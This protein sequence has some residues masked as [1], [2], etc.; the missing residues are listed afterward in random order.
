M[1]NFNITLAVL[2]SISLLLA[3]FSS[4]LWMVA[5]VFLAKIWLCGMTGYWI[6]SAVVNI[7][8]ASRQ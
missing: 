5:V 2:T 6:A 3:Y 7:I 1:R 8:R 4:I